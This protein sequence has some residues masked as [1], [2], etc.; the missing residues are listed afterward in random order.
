[1]LLPTIGACLTGVIGLI[2]FFHP[3]LMLTPMQIQLESPSAV[4]EARAVF[5]GMNL[6]MAVAALWLNTPEIFTA[7]G[8][9]WG[10]LLLAR[11]WSL[12]V[13]GIGLKNAIPGIV[14]DGVLSFLFLSPLL[15]N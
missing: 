9:A 6:G 14:V 4:S 13:D 10:T 1:M 5:G 2:N 12:A 15:L 7:L 8:I 11:F 3:R